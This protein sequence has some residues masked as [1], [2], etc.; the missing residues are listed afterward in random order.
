MTISEL[1]R[2]LHSVSES[3]IQDLGEDVDGNP[4]FA[5]KINNSVG[6]FILGDMDINDFPEWKNLS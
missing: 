6:S 2:K 5:I 4:I 3:D 1:L